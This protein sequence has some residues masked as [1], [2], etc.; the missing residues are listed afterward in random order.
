MAKVEF[1]AFDNNKIIAHYMKNYRQCMGNGMLIY[2]NEGNTFLSKPYEDEPH[3][4]KVYSLKDF[5]PDLL[6]CGSS[7]ISFLNQYIK[8]KSGLI[9]LDNI[10][11]YS[12]EVDVKIIEGKMTPV[13]K[14]GFINEDD[15]AITKPIFDKVYA[16]AE[17]KATV[18]IKHY[19]CQIDT[20]GLPLFN[21][22][23]CFNSDFLIKTS[24]EFAFS[25]KNNKFGIINRY[26]YLCVP[27]IYDSIQLIDYG[28]YYY[29]KLKKKKEVYIAFII[30]DAICNIVA[31][32]PKSL[33]G[34]N[35]YVLIEEEITKD[36]NKL[37]KYGL[38]N[39]GGLRL[40]DS[41]YDSI[42]IVSEH[43]VIVTKNGQKKLYN[44]S[45]DKVKLVLGPS[46]N[47]KYGEAYMKETKE[48][49]Y[50]ATDNDY[51]IS[52][53]ACEKNNNFKDNLNWTFRPNDLIKDLNIYYDKIYF[54]YSGEPNNYFAVV[55]GDKTELIDIDEKQVIPFVIPS[56]YLVKTDTYAE[57]IV[58][59]SKLVEDDIDESIRKYGYINADGQMLTE[60]KYDVVYKFE[61]GEGKAKYY[62]DSFSTI[63]IID[64]DG[65][66]IDY[67][68]E[69]YDSYTSDTTWADMIDDAFE[70]DPDAYWNI[71]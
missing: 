15:I 54:T 57:N 68:T 14:Y 7:N 13:L 48:K 50:Y 39:R 2:D 30:D 35:G 63:D 31:L 36:D 18:C 28:H 62:D 21:D 27:H 49:Y 29:F 65:N 3:R 32:N 40:L 55:A 44:T 1:V 19:Q 34:K 59:V 45:Q 53:L 33:Y 43:Y 24:N 69:S 52:M 64:K 16:F 26:R 42:D 6:E 56:E 9:P 58:G 4:I 66:Q 8:L 22:K 41:E 5:E 47:I 17:G 60:F 71:D 23:P 46:D 25:I 67:I 12:V 38:L 37:T 51:A 11:V 20:H 10:R 70:G 61:N